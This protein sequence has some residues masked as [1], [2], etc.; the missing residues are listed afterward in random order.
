MTPPLALAANVTPP[1]APSVPASA[2]N[3][4]S[5]G[6]S[7]SAFAA[8]LHQARQQQSA[9]RPSAS[10]HAASTA[11]ASTSP[12]S[13]TTS[14]AAAASTSTPTSKPWNPAGKDS[15]DDDKQATTTNANPPT[16]AAAAMLAL[17]GQSIPANAAP[18]PAAP[19]TSGSES[20]A[21]TASTLQ[22][23]GMPG[24]PLS[25][26]TQASA[27]A[28]ADDT[29]DASTATDGLQDSAL[30][31]LAG[32]ADDDTTP[33]T[34]AAGA[35][36][37]TATQTTPAT[38]PQGDR[39]DPLD[40]LRNLTAP[41]VQAQ[42]SAP[43]AATPH[44]MTMNASVGTPSFAQELGQHVAW[45]G[46]QDIKEARITLHPEDL[47][48]LEVKVS[49]QHDHVDVSF[50][51]QHPNA[52]HA[53]QQTLSQLDSMLAHHGLTLGQAQVEQGN[54]GGAGQGATPGS[55]GSG[56]AGAADDGD[57]AQVA[58]PVVQALGLLDTFA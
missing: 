30:S 26:T 51:A 23:S 11:N 35:K 12:S 10:T 9:Q 58:T 29:A 18:T 56:D 3:S 22:V 37:A 44:A 47:G 6:R 27:Q 55:S 1:S 34:T 2:G 52:V 41:F 46:G 7:P 17:L 57:V 54:H 19:A 38:S 43:I 48:Q 31:A 36:L 4:S 20:A 15:K 28:D 21:V 14:T 53:V 13:S 49:V 40:A 25:G 8:P 33:M 42:A 45:L 32:D 16:S 39:S 50:I 24:M 5:D